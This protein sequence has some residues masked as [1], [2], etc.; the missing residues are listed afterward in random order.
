[1]RVLVAG[2]GNPDR[3]DD[4][5]GVVVVRCAAPRLPAEVLVLERTE[6]ADLVELL[7]GIQAAFLVDGV[8]SGAPPGTVHRFDVSGS[9]LPP[10]VR[11]CSTHG[12]GV[13]DAVE[14]ARVLGWLPPRTVVYGVE[15]ASVQA[16]QGLTPPVRRA[17]E[18]VGR[19][20]CEEVQGLLGVRWCT[21]G[22]WQKGS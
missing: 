15:V 6:P 11:T 8:V 7:A 22:T 5:V 2:V 21:S 20:L 16:G 19:R 14:L 10:S 9:P 18:E 1:M 17:A 12:L 13:A 3:W 4:G